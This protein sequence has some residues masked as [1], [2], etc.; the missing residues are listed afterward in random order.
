MMYE[1]YHIE[2]EIANEVS[3]MYLTGIGTTKFK[4][5]KL[6]KALISIADELI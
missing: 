6:E 5:K 4:L 2:D 3:V 1:K